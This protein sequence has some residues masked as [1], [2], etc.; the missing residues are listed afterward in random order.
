MHEERRNKINKLLTIN[1][2][3]SIRRISCTMCAPQR[4]R[5]IMWLDYGSES[6]RY[7]HWFSYHCFVHYSGHRITKTII[8]NLTVAFLANSTQ[9]RVCE[10]CALKH[11]T[12]HSVPS[13][14]L[15]G[16]LSRGMSSPFPDDRQLIL[17][18]LH[19]SATWGRVMMLYDR[20][21]SPGDNQSRGPTLKASA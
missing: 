9:Y 19:N 11:R 2:I 4:L 13:Q 15:I 14:F 12:W 6:V 7:S 8:T 16:T 5:S 10:L 1:C 18:I 17:L 21:G 3:L 20:V